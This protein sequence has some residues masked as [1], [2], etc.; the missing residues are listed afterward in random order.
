MVRTELTAD[1]SLAAMRARNR[2]GIAMAAMIRMIATTISNSISEKP[3]CFRISF[4]PFSVFSLNLVM[5]VTITWH[6]AAQNGTTGI[7][8]LERLRFQSLR[9]GSATPYC[10]DQS[11]RGLWL[12]DC[13]LGNDKLCQLGNPG[14]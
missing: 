6:L 8:M 1:D 7:E 2:F 13:D 11:K 3:F 10:W 9:D 12:P 5:V 14:A 4:L